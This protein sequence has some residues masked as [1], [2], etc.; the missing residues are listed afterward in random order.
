[1][2][3][4]SKLE[5]VSEQIVKLLHT[6]L[7]DA[8]LYE[9]GAFLTSTGIFLIANA[10]PDLWPQL[11]PTA[12]LAHELLNQHLN[13]ERVNNG[14]HQQDD[15]GNTTPNLGSNR[16]GAG[17]AT[18]REE[19]IPHQES[20]PARNEEQPCNVQEYAPPGLERKVLDGED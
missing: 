9:R 6:S 20:E 17:E 5:E 4:E 14:N 11:K 3:P 8:E 1:M 13:K 10:I 12:T 16:H 15:G 18:G 2:I 7:P 19:A